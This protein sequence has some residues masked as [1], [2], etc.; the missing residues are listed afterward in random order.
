LDDANLDENV[1]GIMVYYPVFGGAQDQ[2]LKNSIS[3]KKDVEGLCHTYINNMYHNVRF[4]DEAKTLKCILP[5]TPLAMIKILEFIGVYNN[6]LP[7]G[8]RLHGKTVTVINR[9]EVVGRPL[10]SLMA[11][12]GANVYS[13]D[14]ND[15]LFMHRGSGLR[16]KRHEVSE[17]TVTLAMALEKSDVVISG[18]PTAAYKVDTSALKEGVI[19]INFSSYKNFDD[20]IKSRASIYVPTV[21]KVTIAM[22]FRNLLRLK[23]QLS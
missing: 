6:I 2:Y 17:T 1:H 19:A 22:L 21:G 3:L 20:D 18:V 11:N 7:Y 12:D 9:S 8:N 10:A 4:L 14:V 5:C 15:I 13:V 16:L 23:H